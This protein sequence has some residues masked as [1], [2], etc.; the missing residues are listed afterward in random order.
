M[1]AAFY[2]LSSGVFS[3]EALVL[4]LTG[5]L[6]NLPPEQ[7]PS[8]LRSARC[9]SLLRLDPELLLLLRLPPA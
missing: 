1:I 2:R 8:D 5:L 9:V 6:L 4:N 3:R 7:T